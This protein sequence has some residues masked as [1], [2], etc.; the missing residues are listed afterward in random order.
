M[1]FKNSETDYGTIA[2]T[3]HWLMAALVIGLLCVGLYM[4]DLEMG[5]DKLKLYGLHK[6]FGTLVLILVILRLLW[7]FKNTAPALPA[8]MKKHE[9]LAAHAGHAA[10]YFLMLYMP[11]VGWLMSSAAGFPVS[12]F[13]LFALPNLVSPDKQLME[14]LKELH[15]I[16]GNAFIFV[17][18]AHFGAALYHHFIRKDNILRRM[19]PLVLLLVFSSPAFAATPVKFKII[20]EQSSI[21][22]EATPK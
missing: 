8:D 5:P 3:F 19:L 9:K 20:P 22:F 7:R 18:A 2:K 11:I 17:I 10:L 16:G 12:F 21:T 14:L 15:E 6:E 4:S 1:P 13:G